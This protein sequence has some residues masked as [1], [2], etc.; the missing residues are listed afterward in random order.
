M[1]HKSDAEIIQHMHNTARFFTENR[2]ISWVV[3]VGVVLWG[4][5][6]YLKMPKR[7]DPDI[8]VRVATAVTPWP[9]V[10]AEKVEQLVTRRVEQKIAENLSVREPGAYDY[11]IKSVSLD[12]LSIVF[13]QLDSRVKLSKA[14]FDNIDLKL[15]KITDLPQGA[16]PIQFNGDFGDTA[17]LMLTVASPKESAVAISLRARDIRNAVTA[18]RAQTLPKQL[19]R[20]AALVVAFPHSIKPEKFQ[21]HRDLLARYMTEQAV[22]RDIRPIQGSGFL[23]FDAA[24]DADDSTILSSVREFIHERLHSD[25]IDPDVWQPMVVRDPQ[26]TEIKI[27]AVAGAKY[28]YRELDDFTDLIQR[29]LRPVPQVSKVD[30]AGVLQQAVY[31]EYSQERLASY[32]IQPSRLRELL[33][34]RNI[35]EPGG[36]VNI[37][38]KN[39]LI[40]PSGEFHRA[41]E[42]GDVLIPTST[43]TPLYLRDVVEVL[44]SYQSPARYLNFYTSRDQTG[45]WYRARSITLALQMRSGEQI[46]Q[47]GEAVNQALAAVRQQLPADLIIERSSDQP[48]QVDE[49]V[50]LFMSALYEAIILVVVVSWLGFWEWR[51][52]LLMAISIPLTLAMTFG[53]IHVL[54]IDVQQVSIAALIIALGLLV[55]DP[56]V[57]GD[58]IKR[59]LALG[60]PPVVAAWLGPTKLAKAIMFATITNIAAYLPFLLLTGDT[61]DFLHSLPIVMTCSLIAS[62]LVSMTCIPLIGYYLLRPSS[63]PE[64]PM[65]YRREHGFTGAYHRIGTWAIHHRWAAFSGSLLFLVIGGLLMTQLKTQF[66]PDDLQYL[67][68]LDVWLPTDAPVE[69]TNNAA[70]EAENVIRAVADEY[71]RA[72]PAKDGK[73]ERVLKSITSFVGGGGPRFWFSVSPEIQQPNYA[74]LIVEVVDKELT[75]HLVAPLQNAL[76]RKIPGARIDLRQ[77]QTNP[78]ENPI[79]IRIAGQVDIGTVN[80]E[81]QMDTLRALANQVKDIFRRIPIAERVRDDWDEK[82]FVVRLQ[83]DPDRANL[84]EIS[85][86]DVAA[87]STAAMSGMTVNTLREGDKQIPI[88]ARLRLEERAQLSDIQNLYIYSALSPNKVPLRTI[89]SIHNDLETRKIARRDHFR[90]ISVKAFPTAGSLPSEVLKQ[91]QPQLAKFTKALPPGYTMTIG[92]EKAKQD[93]GFGELTTVLVMSIAL[94]FLALVSQFNH[95]VKP[96]LVFA[97]VPYGVVGALAALYIMRTP[98]GFMAFL[99][100]VSLVGVIVSHVIVLF[101]FIEEMHEQGEPLIDSLLDAGIERL[102]PVMITVGATVFALFPLALHGGPLWEPLCYAQIGGLT[103]ATF[104]ELLLVPVL[105]AIF[106]LD[107]KI[108]KW[109]E[110]QVA[111]ETTQ[112][113]TT[114]N[115]AEMLRS[116]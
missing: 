30:R 25:E 105:Y 90:T 85:N 94:I 35:T 59:D 72:H 65:E 70:F 19:S 33:S 107:L 79:E 82:S 78:V 7:K 112:P 109:E 5:Y 61:G 95:A 66:F 80:D 47:F 2:Q 10:K 84:A 15:K 43:G 69:V 88:V 32:G 77:L 14:E 12:G 68:Y 110:V 39:L 81:S 60:H 36:S 103:V 53:M 102:R 16:G 8:P 6:G 100:I 46:H 50:A 91:A 67:S 38:G 27:S 93:E 13:V 58:A 11:G 104:V 28:S 48:R 101:D 96:L 44:R 98:F 40:D 22:V 111:A 4:V 3:L 41:E 74:Q 26:Q 23:G 31:L 116:T 97:A 49:N 108:V 62:R 37:E 115:E 83:I 64:R 87:S 86:L 34:V 42:I 18:A 75:P 76:S 57:A 113:S 45:A 99:G 71:G 63:K 55:D 89:S 73:P 9:G 106:V 54:G 21:R 20:R 92:G 29:T 51:S 17:A 56:V 52:A 1:A 114:L 24:T